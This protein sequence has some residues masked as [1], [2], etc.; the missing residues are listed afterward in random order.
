MLSAEGLP[1]SGSLVPALALKPPL[2]S[3]TSR[4]RSAALTRAHVWIFLECSTPQQQHSV[5]WDARQLLLH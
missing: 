4:F 5:H 1:L 3:P 2:P